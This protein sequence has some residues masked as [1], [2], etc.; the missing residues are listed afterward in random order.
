MTIMGC[1]GNQNGKCGRERAQTVGRRKVF[2]SR[3]TSTL[4]ISAY[5]ARAPYKPMPCHAALA[6]SYI[7]G[8]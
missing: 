1:A 4:K 2:M 7:K 3:S 8:K 6:M 5:Y